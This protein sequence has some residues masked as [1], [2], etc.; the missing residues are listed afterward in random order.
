MDALTLES[1]SANDQ[2]AQRWW[3]D[4]AI[5]LGFAGIAAAT[6]FSTTIFLP[7][8]LLVAFP[9]YAVRYVPFIPFDGPDKIV[10]VVYF[11]AIGVLIAN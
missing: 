5:L 1:D 7:M 9:A 4:P 3:V 11:L 6:Y 10:I 2:C 8:T